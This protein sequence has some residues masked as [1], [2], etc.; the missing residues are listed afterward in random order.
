MSLRFRLILSFIFIIVLCLA[1]IAVSLLALSQNYRDRVARAR[2]GD[3]AAPVYFQVKSLAQ[4]KASLEQ[5][6]ASLNEQ[7]QETGT[8]I[9][10]LNGQGK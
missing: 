4:G 1:V 10:I 9:F 8:A 7:S 5:V 6:W 2:L 3:I